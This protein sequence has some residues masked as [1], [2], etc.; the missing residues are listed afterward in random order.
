MYYTYG[1]NNMAREDW[2]TIKMPRLMIQALDE[3]L[4]TDLA[5]K[6][7]IFSRADL[8]V[9]ICS[10]WFSQFEKEFGLFVPREAL[11]GMKGFNIMKPYTVEES[12]E[13]HPSAKPKKKLQVVA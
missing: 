4:D 2:I 7:G 6:N 5:K 3:F 1:Y 9:R 8:M 10:T 11:R 12:N 13:D